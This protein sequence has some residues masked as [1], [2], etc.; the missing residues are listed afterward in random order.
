M[1]IYDIYLYLT[2]RDKTGVR[3]ITKFQG[4]KQTPIRLT[5]D[6]LNKLQLPSILN[7]EIS[8]IISDNK[9]LW[10]PWIQ[11][12][13]TFDD[14]VTNLK[15]SGYKNIPNLNRQEL[16]FSTTQLI[17]VKYLPQNNTM[18]RKI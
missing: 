7:V 11:S 2:K 14:F 8:Q 15:N 5:N 13:E 18:L 16:K 12:V 6:Y 17:N 9:M 3:I 10:E 1:K 4:G